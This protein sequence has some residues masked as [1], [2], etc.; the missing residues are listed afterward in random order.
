MYNKN[1]YLTILTIFTFLY[2][3]LQ[4]I[5]MYK[6]R[7]IFPIMK[8]GFYSHASGFHVCNNS[9]GNSLLW[10]SHINISV[11][12]LHLRYLLIMHFM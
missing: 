2:N 7:L 3:L 12:N 6:V 11:N 8:L 1:K 5:F 10:F 4:I 9:V